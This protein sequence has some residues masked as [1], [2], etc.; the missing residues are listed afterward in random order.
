V[1]VGKHPQDHGFP[2]FAALFPTCPGI[3]MTI[4]ARV[5]RRRMRPHGVAEPTTPFRT[6][7]SARQTWPNSP[8]YGC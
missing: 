7:P 3:S 8:W 4:G 6:L 1:F 5:R 2:S